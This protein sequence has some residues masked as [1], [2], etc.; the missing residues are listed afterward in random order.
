MSFL[1]VGRRKGRETY[2][3]DVLIHTGVASH[4]DSDTFSI[5]SLCAVVHN[6]SS[7]LEIF[8]V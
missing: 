5:N 4:Y 2:F 7:H 6:R 8:E 3:A 1:A